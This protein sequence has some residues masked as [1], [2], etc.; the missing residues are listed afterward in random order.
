MVKLTVQY[1]IVQY[2]T[3][4]YIN[5][6]SNSSNYH[7]TSRSLPSMMELV[8]KRL[9][10]RSTPRPGVAGSLSLS[11]ECTFVNG[12]ES[13]TSCS[14][15]QGTDKTT[16]LDVVNTHM[17]TNNINIL[18]HHVTP[19][20]LSVTVTYDSSIIVCRTSY[21]VQYTVLSVIN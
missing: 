19:L 12:T 2:S 14:Q 18:H 3:V 7:F 20:I 10:L 9:P 6:N 15:H 11:I 5:S 16:R 21:V 8:R 1:S 13:R 4:Q 17:Y